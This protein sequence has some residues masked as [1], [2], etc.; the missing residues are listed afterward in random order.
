MSARTAE[1]IQFFPGPAQLVTCAT[2]LG[3]SAA[4]NRLIAA[5][6]S[7]WILLLDADMLPDHESF[8]MDYF[9]AMSRAEG[10]SLIAGGFSVEKVPSQE[11]CKLHYSQALVSDGQSA[12]RRSQEPGRFVF[13]SNIL[14][15]RKVLDTVG[16]DE[17][18]KGWGWEDVDWG[19]RVA[20]QFPIVHIDNT[21]TH[22][23]LED[24]QT[25]IRKFTTSG[26]NFARLVQRHPE[27]CAQMPLLKAAR[28]VKHVPLAESAGRLIAT[29]NFL[30]QKVRLAGLKLCRAA[31]YARYL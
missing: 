11:R 24:D 26:A 18:F 14:V 19:L 27:A 7:D 25:L 31:A 6:R 21:A 17:G 9:A 23:G 29:S 15:H 30:P 12:A 4:R 1:A 28:R 20:D 5:A 16:F 13:T 3:R 10:P 8:L 2:N 22:L